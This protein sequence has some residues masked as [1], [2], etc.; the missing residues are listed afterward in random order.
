MVHRFLDTGDT[1]YAF[2]DHFLVEC[3]RCAKCAEVRPTPPTLKAESAVLVCGACG[4][5]R[6][7]KRQSKRSLSKLPWSSAIETAGVTLIG[8]SVD[9]YF[10]EPLWLRTPCCGQELWAYNRRH[11]TA[12]EEY[13][14]ADLRESVGTAN[15]SWASRLPPWM[16]SAKKRPEVLKC[17]KKLRDKD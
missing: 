5:T 3:P 15:G 10:R 11:L 13:V 14:A 2:G 1:L 17:I 9:W 16:K 6:T 12:L 7:W 8:T 4:F